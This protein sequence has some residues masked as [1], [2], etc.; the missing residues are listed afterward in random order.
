M[1]LRQQGL[2]RVVREMASLLVC[3]F[4]A[5]RLKALTALRNMRLRGGQEIADF[6]VALEN[7]ARKANSMF[8]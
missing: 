5:A 3:V 4:T 8:H 2:D 1:G 6:C 7:L